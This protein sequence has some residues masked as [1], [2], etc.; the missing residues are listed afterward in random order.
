MNLSG[1]Q[2]NLTSRWRQLSFRSNGSGRRLFWAALIYLVLLAT[3]VSGVMPRQV[4][5]KAG[6]IAPEEIKAQKT[7]T[8]RRATDAKKEEARA[9]VKEVYDMDLTVVDDAAEQVAL[10]YDLFRTAAA[11]GQSESESLASLR[12]SLPFESSDNTILS[13]LR[14]DRAGIDELATATSQI[15][16]SVMQAGIKEERL[17]EAQGQ[18]AAQTETLAAT[19]EQRN[20][21]AALGKH[22]LRPNLVFNEAMTN[23]RRAEAE[24]AVE[25]D[26]VKILNGQIIVRSGDLVTP[27]HIAMLEDLGLLRE[28]TDYWRLLGLALFVLLMEAL[29]AVY[30]HRFLRA[31][32]HNESHIILLGLIVI[33]TLLLSRIL[34][35]ISAYLLPVAA[36][37]ILVAVLLDARLAV[38]INMVL[39]ILAGIILGGELRYIVIA[40]IG[41]YAGIYSISK[42]TQRSDLTRAGAN[43][44]AANVL[45]IFGTAAA[46]GV[47][48]DE[49]LRESVLGTLG[50]AGGLLSIVLA[51]G[52][53]PYLE[54]NFGIT[55]AV[56][57]SELS[58]PSHPLLRRLLVEA[59]GT[60]HHSII[61]GNLAEAAVETVGGEPLLAR[62]GAY[63]HDIGKIKRPY[64]FIENQLSGGN[65]H[66]NVSP[67]LSTL[68][69]TSHIKDG[70]E[71]A[72]EY[73][74][75]PVIIDII[76][77]HHGTSLVAYFYNLAAG[78]D[79]S[80]TVTEEDFRYEGPKP[81]TKEAAAVMLADSVEAATRSLAKP[82]P[83]RIAD[84]VYKIIKGRL[85]DGQLDESA[86][87][88]K[89][90]DRIAE[91]FTRILLGIF[92]SRIEYPAGEEKE[93]D[94]GETD[95][96]TDWQS[97]D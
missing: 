72:R 33:M 38:T 26:P 65:P 61:V 64:F 41:G 36:G 45:A 43:V 14:L 59:P 32:F 4:Q 80:D 19:R 67:N 30:L 89:D 29:V 40:L 2:S 88:F 9:A 69:I 10:V 34:G 42:V 35:T 28:H 56:K 83:E 94:G 16:R 55:T 70:V 60:Y 90:L 22:V 47:P 79:K 24:L 25:A 78:K 7:V 68:M 37:A 51:N 52:L 76:E 84:V 66:D 74:L 77:Q 63:Y 13:V 46:A 91:S 97:S 53:L 85:D 81:Q 62:A 17:P 15:V 95:G 86:L 3:V 39:S 54:N 18:I 92:H 73:R 23:Q 58:N 5:I 6:E 48:F 50:I 11:S 96:S 20:F 31:S 12:E 21:A 71:L 57:L 27:E 49:V 82:T 87:T 8:N 44:G 93:A 1:W 75:P